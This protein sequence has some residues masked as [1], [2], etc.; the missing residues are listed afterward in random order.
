MSTR[1][2]TSS[3][4][5]AC[6]VIAGLHVF[7]EPLPGIAPHA[8]HGADLQIQ[9]LG[10]FLVRES[11]KVLHLNER[12]PLG[13]C[14]PELIQKAVDR[15]REIQFDAGSGEQILN[16]LER[17]KLRTRTS[18][19]MVDKVA[20]HSSSSYSEKMLS[21]LPISIFGRD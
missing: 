13:S 17:D 4:F 21:I 12:A 14:F 9:H 7:K 3:S 5:R 16:S 15:N 19:R 10:R 1:L 11:K 18:A 2:M 8:L 6:L 20:A